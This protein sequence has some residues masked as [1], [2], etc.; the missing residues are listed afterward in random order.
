MNTRAFLAVM[1]GMTVVLGPRL[2]AQDKTEVPPVVPG[3]K[4]AAV[5]HIKI[6]GTVLEGNLEGM[7][8]IE[9]F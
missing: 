5:E 6:H 1:M 8:R 4:P 9:T 2:V 7:R 3:A